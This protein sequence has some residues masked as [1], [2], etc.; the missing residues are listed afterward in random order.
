MCLPCRSS[1]RKLPDEENSLSTSPDPDFLTKFLRIGQTV[2][3]PSPIDDEI[4]TSTINE[5][6]QLKTTLPFKILNLFCP[7]SSYPDHSIL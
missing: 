6:T 1:M 4:I 7:L 3:D 2:A 5:Y